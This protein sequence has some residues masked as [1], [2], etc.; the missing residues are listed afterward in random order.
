LDGLY[1]SERG[2]ITEDWT[3]GRS[4]KVK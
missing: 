3:V 2:N 4:W 1:V